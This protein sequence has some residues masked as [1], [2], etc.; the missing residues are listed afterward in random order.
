MHKIVCLVGDFIYFAFYQ[1]WPGDGCTNQPK[2]VAVL[3]NK[4]KVRV[5]KVFIPL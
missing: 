3:Y 4:N 1:F 2:H 5:D